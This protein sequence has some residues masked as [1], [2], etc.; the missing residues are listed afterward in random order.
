M[1]TTLAPSIRTAPLAA[2]RWLI[3]LVLLCAAGVRAAEPTFTNVTATVAPGLAE[4]SGSSAAPSQSRNLVSPGPAFTRVVSGGER[5]MSIPLD[6]IGATAQQQYSGDGL[7]VCATEGGAGLRC[8]F[9]R[10]EGEVTGEGLWLTSTAA[11]TVHDRFR[12]TA[13]SVERA[14]RAPAFLSPTGKVEVAGQVVRFI[15]PGLIEEYRRT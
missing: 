1:K 3:T 2:K 12:V 11:N 13:A 14:T 4:I 8:V 6:Q 10:M 5:A 7:S 15:R 9:Q